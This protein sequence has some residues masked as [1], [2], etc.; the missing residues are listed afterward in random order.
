MCVM[1][2]YTTQTQCMYISIICSCVGGNG[3]E[4]GKEG[5]IDGPMGEKERGR[6][7]WRKGRG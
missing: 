3:W 2:R 6:E 1:C 4:K 7:G 5:G